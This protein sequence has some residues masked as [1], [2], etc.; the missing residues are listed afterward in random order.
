MSPLHEFAKEFDIKNM[1]A[2]VGK[3]IRASL[4]AIYEIK[5]VLKFS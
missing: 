4:I 5:F 2:N 1:V 3:S